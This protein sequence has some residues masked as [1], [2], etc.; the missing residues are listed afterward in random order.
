MGEFV[1][2]VTF[3]RNIIISAIFGLLVPYLLVT[4]LDPTG[5][6]LNSTMLMT[7]GAIYVVVYSMFGL[8]K[9]ETVIRFIIGIAYVLVVVYFYTVGHTI[10]TLYLPH[11]GFGYFCIWGTVFGIT[12]SFGYI[13]FITA[14][15]VIILKCLNLLRHLVKPPEEESKYKVKALEKMKLR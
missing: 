13:Y 7:N 10:F 3:I 14:L 9:K 2:K 4:Y 11:C 12:I 6:V 5:Y 15:V 1:N 8:F